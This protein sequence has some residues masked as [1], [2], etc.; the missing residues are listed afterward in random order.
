MES[1]LPVPWAP[2]AKPVVGHLPEFLRAP[3]A[4]LRGL[5]EHGPLVEIRLAHKP[6][7]VVCDPELTRTVLLHDRVFDKGGPLFERLREAGGQGLATCPAA[8]HRR[9][10]RLMQP[11]FHQARFPHY[12]RIMTERISA[13][14]GGW[15]DGRTLDLAV[16]A[17]NITADIVLSTVFGTS[18]DP[19]LHKR[20]AADFD[21]LL[22]GFTRHSLLPRPLR[23]VPTPGNV[24]YEEATRRVRRS[25]ADLTAA[26]RERAADGD[27]EETSLLSMLI[28]ARDPESDTP[29]LT[30][31]ELVDQAVTM[32]SAGT[33]TTAGAVNW[34]L[35]LAAT[36][37]A[38]HARLTAEVNEVLGG[39][40]AGWDDLPRLT[41]TRQVFTEALR[42][43]PPGWFLTRQTETDT[44]LGGYPLPK[45]TTL[46]YS[47]YL[48]SHL[49]DLYPD[50]QRFDPDRWDAH[51]AGGTRPQIPVTVFGGGAR[52]CIGDEFSQIEGVLLLASL[53]SHWRIH[54]HRD[55]LSVPRL[56]QLTLNPGRMRVTLTAHV[57]ETV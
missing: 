27:G 37:P 13:V 41:Y 6:V 29:A 26:Y 31:D 17:R 22:A 24:R 20:L 12:A 33:E 23:K 3:L 51:G 52:K 46:A 1:V 16:E 44:R 48:I 5:P 39:R 42:M 56:P 47:P 40:T 14:V 54:L 25:M 18:L 21:T 35:Y 19:G 34:G 11:A 32:Y 7:V 50:P 8:E 4:F 43:Y 30:D 55:S 15:Q 2:G 38:V 28:A 36:H 53:L 9:Q 10:R 57:R 49:P 45:G